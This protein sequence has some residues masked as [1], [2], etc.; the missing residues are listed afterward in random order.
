[1]SEWNEYMNADNQATQTEQPQAPQQATTQAPSTPS[2]SADQIVS[3]AVQE[4]SHNAVQEAQR[5]VEQAL[6]VQRF[7]S[8]NPELVPH[9]HLVHAEAVRLSNEAENQGITSQELLKKASDSIR[10]K[11]NV[12]PTAKTVMTL[13]AGGSSSQ[14]G[15]ASKAEQLSQM[16]PDEF[17]SYFDKIARGA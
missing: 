8:E 4:S 14:Q 11:L 2:I 13:D 6:L 5:I 10:E 9:Q 16:K 3:R 7:Q 12:K 15:G 17:I 1:M